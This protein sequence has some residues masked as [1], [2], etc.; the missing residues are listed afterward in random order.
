M[1]FLAPLAIA[2]GGMLSSAGLTTI[3][4]ALSSFAAGG[5]AT[6][7]GGAFGA[8]LS[9]TALTGLGFT[10]PVAAATAG[11]TGALVAG[12]GAA[13]SIAAPAAAS[14]FN[15]SNVLAAGSLATSA[16]SVGKSLLTKVP[17][18]PDMPKAIEAKVLPQQDSD[19]LKTAKKRSIV[20]Q[21]A[22]GGRT[23]TMLSGGSGD[24]LGN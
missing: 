2:A 14:A 19:K 1:P 7:A 16:A 24:S 15:T 6:A 9:A 4:G 3:G 12:A 22:R 18:M 13:G 20:Q 11:G 10:A 21:R 17:G 8:G 23:S 5:A